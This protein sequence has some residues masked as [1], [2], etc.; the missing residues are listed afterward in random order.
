MTYSAIGTNGHCILD[1]A[2]HYLAE[3]GI[4]GRTHTVKD[5]LP[6]TPDS[7]STDSGV[8]MEVCTFQSGAAEPEYT[9]VPS[10]KLMYNAD[11]IFYK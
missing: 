5:P 3:R 2:Y 4:M 6:Q 11:H 10:G 9:H 1:D 8:G 7:V